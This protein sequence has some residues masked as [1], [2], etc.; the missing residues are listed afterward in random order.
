VRCQAVSAPGHDGGGDSYL[1][2]QQLTKPARDVT[3]F[4]ELAFNRNATAAANS[5]VTKPEF[6]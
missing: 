6:T 5:G 3:E 4:C 1:I 2:L